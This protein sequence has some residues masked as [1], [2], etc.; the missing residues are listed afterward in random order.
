M[1]P[2]HHKRGIATMAPRTVHPS[3][4]LFRR[5]R[6][7]LRDAPGAEPSVTSD[8]KSADTDLDPS[9]NGEPFLDPDWPDEPSSVNKSLSFYYLQN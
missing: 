9:S 3:R 1:I 7:T 2:T 5:K 8:L 4:Q 6:V